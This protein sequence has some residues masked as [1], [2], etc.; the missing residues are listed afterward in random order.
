MAL[1]PAP[2]ARTV[3]LGFAL[4]SLI[5]ILPIAL[6]RLPP[7]LDY[8]NHMARMHILAAGV[9]AALARYYAVHWTPLPDLGADAIVPLLAQ[10]MPVETAMRLFLAS[11]LLG[12]AGGCLVLHRVAFRR[13]SV[14]PLFAFLLLYNRMLLWGFI[15]YLTGITL[16][17]WALA[18]WLA[19][20]GRPW[21]ARLAAGLIFSTAIYLAHLAAFGCYALALVALALGSG[22][23][24][25]PRRLAV[26]VVTLAPPIIL[27]LLAPT[28]GAPVGFAYGNLLR[29]LDLPVS[30]F[31]NYNRVFDG[32][33]FGILLA[34]T[35]VALAR[36]AV[37]L[38]GRLRWSLLAVLAAFILLPSRF[39]SA[40]GIDHRLPVAIALMFL[41][42][43]DWSGVDHKTRRIVAVA[44]FALLAI[45]MTIIGDVWLKADRQYTSL[46]PAFDAI[47]PGAAVAVAAP[48]SDV[49]AGGVPLLHF[50]TIAVIKRDAF[51][52]TLFADRFQ[53]P[54]TL[55]RD[56][57][58]LAG[59]APPAVLWQKLT[60]GASL[61]LPGYD[62][63]MII[64]PPHTINPASL[65]EVLFAAP[66]LLLV[67]LNPNE[68]E[69]R[70]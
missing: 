5:T 69:R 32:A 66:R 10:V 51:V 38:H 63:L 27:F 64:D 29:K 41:G 47:M 19:M 1:S 50:P 11:I 33:T 49:Q 70:P 22:R 28:S 60:E 15:N 57:E 35:I 12:L 9:S 58:N 3:L 31:D 16:V 13:W 54:V 8:P 61:S 37:V 45:R 36:R 23:D 2:R 46:M 25:W 24:G 65:G 4:L 6:T 26:V 44:L 68:G 34:A 62:D 40:S 30:I 59:E 53:Q 67:R 39:L 56:A 7:I 43:S 55:T 52:P 21:I 42:M 18:A 17:L 20:E 48:S 14:W